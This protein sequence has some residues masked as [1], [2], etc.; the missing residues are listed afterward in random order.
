MAHLLLLGAGFTPNWD[1]WLAGQ[2]ADDLISRLS[3]NRNLC[4]RL[5]HNPDFEEVGDLQR[6]WRHHQQ[7]EH[8]ERLDLMER[9]VRASFD[10]NVLYQLL[11]SRK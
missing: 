10:D 5:T 9:A 7:P 11:V 8:R 6:E 2:L 3:D 4:K 1:G